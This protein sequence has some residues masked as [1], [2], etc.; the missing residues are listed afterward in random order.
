MRFTSGNV[1]DRRPVLSFGK[2]LF[3][4]LFGDRGY[5]SENL[6]F[7]L[8]SFGVEYIVKRRSNMKKRSHSQMDQALL[9]KRS[10]IETIFGEMKTQTNLEH[11]RHRSLWNFYVNLLSSLVIYNLKP[12]KPQVMRRFIEEALIQ[13]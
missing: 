4:K 6:E 9:K 8:K 11:T 12:N 13:Y 7:A 10:I 1:D 5:I 3:G 2:N